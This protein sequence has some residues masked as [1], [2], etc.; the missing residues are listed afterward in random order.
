LNTLQNDGVQ[1]SPASTL[2]GE[3]ENGSGLTCRRSPAL[4]GPAN[5]ATATIAIKGKS[6]RRN[7]TVTFATHPA[8]LK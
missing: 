5:A 3:W 7:M 2:H 8:P 4:D 6:M 1:G